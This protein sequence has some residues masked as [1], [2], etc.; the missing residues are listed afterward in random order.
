LEKKLDMLES[1]MS[2][3]FEL[4]I[5]NIGRRFESQMEK[6]ME[7]THDK[8]GSGLRDMH[9]LVEG[10]QSA[11]EAKVEF[12]LFSQ[13]KAHSQT[14]EADMKKQFDELTEKLLLQA[15]VSQDEGS[16]QLA[17]AVEQSM[18]QV[19]QGVE[20]ST[21]A[22]NRKTD[23][24]QESLKGAISRLG[25]SITQMMDGW[26]HHTIQES[27]ATA[28]T[29]QT[30]MSQFDEA[31]MQRVVE[32]EQNIAS[33]IHKV[34]GEGMDGISNTVTMQAKSS[35]D[36]LQASIE[37]TKTVASGTHSELESKLVQM[38]KE[39]NND[40][41]KNIEL[42]LGVVGNSL[43]A[44]LEGLQ[45]SQLSHHQNTESTISMKVDSKLTSM[46][47]GL[48]TEAQQLAA[49]A[50]AHQAQTQKQLEKHTE[51]ITTV[52]ASAN[53]AARGHRNATEEMHST[54]R[55]VRAGTDECVDRFAGLY[56]H[57]GVSGEPSRVPNPRAPLNRGGSASY[58]RGPTR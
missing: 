27:K 40:F 47:Q 4:A 37:A 39:L 54:I 43:R 51:K 56:D 45:A 42:G 41:S 24:F 3:K 46:K 30:K 35:V 34:V 2:D 14:I 29:L 8:F 13:Q 32:I 22:V 12:I 18:T 15:R 28:F 20:Q 55:D 38:V 16:A 33:K 49:Q 17:Q 7:K 58:S 50:Q 10:S 26:A 36:Q 23:E 11:I 6:Y 19:S 31:Q 52:L 25:G 53:E 21:A 57:L 44:Q 9:S 1:Q 48:T 5:E